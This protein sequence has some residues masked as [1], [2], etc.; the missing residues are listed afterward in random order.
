VESYGL[1]DSPEGKEIRDIGPELL[2]GEV[3]RIAAG[4]AMY[5]G[6]YQK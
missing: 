2:K 5:A 3:E 4:Y 6:W 1:A